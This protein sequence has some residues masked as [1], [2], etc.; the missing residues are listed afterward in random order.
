MPSNVIYVLGLGPGDIL[1]LPAR[2]LS[3]LR[4]YPVYLRTERHPVVE[5]LKREGISLHP[6]DH[7]YEE[8]ET[9]EEL[10]QAMTC[11]LLDRCQQEGVVVF[12]VPGSPLVGETVVRLLRESAPQ[13][14]I[15]LEILPAPSFLE[16]LYPLLG[17]DPAEG[18]LIADSFSFCGGF[19]QGLLPGTGLI[20]MQLYSP[21]LASEVKLTLME[22]YPDDHQIMLVRAAG[23]RGSEKVLT[24]PLYELDRQEVDHLTSLYVPPLTGGAVPVDLTGDAVQNEPEQLAQYP[25][26]PLVEV[27][28]SLLSPEGCPWDRKQT[29]QTLKKYLIEESYEVLD[30]IDEGNMHKL[31]EELGDL[32]LQII[33]HAALAERSGKFTI[34]DVISG[35][36]EKMIR[37][38]PHVF[39]DTRVNSAAEVLKNWESIKQ[40]EGEPKSMLAGVPRYLPAL[41]RAQKV[42]GK[43]ALVGFDWPEAEGAALKVEEEWKE[44]KE[45][46]ERGDRQALQSELGDF[47]FAAVNTCRLLGIDAEETLRQAVDKFSQRFCAMERKAAE[48]GL[49]LQDLSLAE[50]DG[51]WDEVKASEE[52]NR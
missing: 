50:L 26:D 23:V 18:L 9:F 45:A 8:Y 40:E 14:N 30:A 51:I 36:T 4:S 43:A 25:L 27:M 33:F 44:V 21:A 37:R 7:F 1:D 39:G 42:Q 34:S 10:Y 15:R 22:S 48:R 38:H 2:N 3:L 11:F 32:L 24:I 19:D 52:K 16:S 46:W 49:R 28:D 41:Q 20:I 12:A 29:H 17:I 6:L 13:K 31:C 35:I 5:Y 47:L